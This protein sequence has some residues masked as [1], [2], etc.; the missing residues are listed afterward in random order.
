[1]KEDILLYSSCG[2]PNYAVPELIN[3]KFYNR[4]SIDI[5]S[6]GVSLFSLLTIS[7]PFKEKQTNKLYQKIK[8]F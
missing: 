6:Y 1:M 2:P 7:L 4:A 5:W 3:G 8:E